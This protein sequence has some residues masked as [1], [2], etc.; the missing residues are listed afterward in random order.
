M[1]LNTRKR[2]R[3]SYK[4]EIDWTVNTTLIGIDF[5][6][7]SPSVCCIETIK[8]QI[9]IIYVGQRKSDY[10]MN[11]LQTTMSYNNINYTV[12]FIAIDTRNIRRDNHVLDHIIRSQHTVECI[13]DI[14]RKLMINPEYSNVRIEGYAYSRMNNSTRILQECGGLLKSALIKAGF[15]SINIITPTSLKKFFTKNG[16]ASKKN[17]YEAFNEICTFEKCKTLLDMFSLNGMISISPVDDIVDAFALAVYNKSFIKSVKSKKVKTHSAERHEDVTSVSFN[18]NHKK[19]KN[20]LTTI[21]I[22]NTHLHKA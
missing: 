20:D 19:Q 5:S 6:L 16:K 2:V 14:L 11:Q 13:M 10:K 15:R 7:R 18:N 8:K 17:M 9:S 4:T 1:K 21:N 22:I 12:E 3:H